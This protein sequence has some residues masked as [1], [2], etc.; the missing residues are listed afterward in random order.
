MHGATGATFVLTYIWPLMM[1][2][3]L[4]MFFLRV[5]FSN[6][7][8]T[9]VCDY[10]GLGLVDG[11]T[12]KWENC[13]QI[14]TRSNKCILQVFWVDICTS[15]PM[16]CFHCLTGC[17]TADLTQMNKHISCHFLINWHIPLKCRLKLPIYKNIDSKYSS[18]ISLVW[19]KKKCIWHGTKNRR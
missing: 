13:W 1:S 7:F 2:N 5:L 11:K 17:D 6:Q 10:S 16:L 9:V 3:N 19:R 12:G 14:I 18:I 8:F 15:W 4:S